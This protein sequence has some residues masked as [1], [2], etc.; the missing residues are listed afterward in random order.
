MQNIH[1]QLAVVGGGSAGVTAAISSAR[2][3]IPTVLITDRPV[4]GGNSSSEIR[5]WTRGATGAGNL[6]AEEMGIWGM[7]KLENLY[8]NPD[9]NPVFWDE[10]L[11]DAVLREPNLTLWLN[12][13][14]YDVTMDGNRIT[15]LG[16]IQQGGEKVL[17]QAA[18]F[19]DA[20]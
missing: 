10:V 4:L 15:G 17:F 19:I 13:V 1:T 6:W 5:V 2:L 14:I 7:L 20:T 9:A 3:G 16:G 18:A 11:L 8:R 12:T